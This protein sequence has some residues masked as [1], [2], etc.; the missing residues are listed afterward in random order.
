MCF[1]KLGNFLDLEIGQNGHGKQ[2]RVGVSIH[3]H[4]FLF[5]L[6]FSYFVST[7]QIPDWYSVIRRRAPKLLTESHN[8]HFDTHH[9]RL[10]FRMLIVG[11]SGSGKTQTLLT[12]I[13]NMRDTFQT[14]H[15]ST[16]NRDEPLYNY[17]VQ[18]F[19][20]M[21]GF[22]IGEGSGSLPPLD[23]LDKKKSNLVVIDDLVTSKNQTMM[24]TYFVR[25][26]KLNCSVIYIS[27]SFYAVPK[28]IRNNLSYLII[29]QV[30]SA[31]NLTMICRE[32]GGL[33]RDVIQGMYSDATSTKGGFLM[34]D[35]ET[36]DANK[37]RRNFDERYVVSEDESEIA[38]M[39]ME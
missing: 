4:P 35:C 16:A 5:F 23:E 29:K 9:I 22:S 18:E 33:S 14:V 11:A 26:R 2:K 21:D 34:I 28:M 39:P 24:E 38:V 10:P 27:Q 20:Q 12:L 31:K 36:S 37:Y 6:F 19:K 1:A 13:A 3:T 32:C 30:S 15:I 17:L 25:C 7:M 8:P